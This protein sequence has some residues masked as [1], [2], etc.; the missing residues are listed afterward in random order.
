MKIP[1]AMRDEMIT[2][3]R[4]KVCQELGIV[5][6]EHQRAWWAR[7]DGQVLM[8]QSK[9]GYPET[10]VKLYDGSL[11][12]RSLHPRENGRAKV[13]AELAAYKAGKSYGAALWAAGFAAV[14]QGRVYLVGIEYDMCAPEFEYL[15]E[16]LLSDRGLKLPYES[17]QNRLVR[18]E[19]KLDSITGLSSLIR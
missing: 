5:P 2:G 13:V 9:L 12:V 18:I 11:A 6:F 10:T 1:P 16:F 4:E 17:L 3:F 7:A 19:N 8:P 14:P 15:L